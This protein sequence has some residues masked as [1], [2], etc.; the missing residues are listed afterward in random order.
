MQSTS[1]ISDSIFQVHV[2]IPFP[3]VSVNCYLVREADGWT[4]IDT[5]LHHLPGFEAWEE[6][7]RELGLQARDLRRI[8][9]THAH[10][11]HYG[12]A[13]HFQNLSGTPVYALDEEIRVVPIEWQRDGA[14]TRALGQFF[15]K[16]GAPHAV[17]EQVAART[18]EVLQM[19]QPQPV[20]T[21]L[22]EGEAVCLGGEAYRVV[23][24]PG[25]A[26]GH[27]L[28]R[29]EADGVTFVGDQILANITPNIA[30]WPGLDSNPLRSY[31]ASLD[32]LERLGVSVALPGHRAVIHDVPGRVRE[33]REHHR[34]RLQACWD[35][36]GDG[37]TAY[38]VCLQVFPRLQNVDDVRMAL[39]ETLAHLEYLAVEGRLERSEESIIRY[40]QVAA[41]AVDR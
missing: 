21:A 23:W 5:G 22:H 41:I 3:L 34:V 27:L 39:V 17:V 36:A 33:I 8:I 29:R 9:L 1:Q 12:L 35:A 25:H 16:H 28:L 18:M 38:E 14:H 6:A 11:D 24:T 19:L 31:L 40:R 20:L 26:D 7:F 37:C 32:K 15:E 2:P 13:G 10:P 30:L 4:M